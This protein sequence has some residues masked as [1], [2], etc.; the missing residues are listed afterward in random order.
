MGTTSAVVIGV[1]LLVSVPVKNAWCRYLCP[2][3]ALL[4][5]VAL[6]SPTRIRRNADVC[7]DCAKCAKD[8]PAG[9]P[10]DRIASVGSA[11]CSACML[12]VT[13]CPAVGA[14]DLSLSKRRILPAWALAAATLTIFLAVVGFARAAGYWQTPVTDAQYR[15]LIPRAAEFAH[16]Q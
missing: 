3:G 10:V 15:D 16:P 6:L 11:E 14:L 2:Y 5:L 8:C 13:A 12:C 4:G 9:L 1:L 7:I